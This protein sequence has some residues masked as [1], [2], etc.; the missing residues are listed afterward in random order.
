MPVAA[1]HCSDCEVLRLELEDLG[2]DIWH[3]VDHRNVTLGPAM[4]HWTDSLQ[5]FVLKLVVMV[6][7]V[8]LLTG[9]R[10]LEAGGQSLGPAEQGGSACNGHSLMAQFLHILQVLVWR[11]VHEFW[12]ERRCRYPAQ[13]GS[14]PLRAE[15]GRAHV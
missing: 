9:G 2:E 15:I 14:A 3:W 1:C 10:D 8:E 13:V 5:A 6:P 12:E 11:G 7:V 4:L